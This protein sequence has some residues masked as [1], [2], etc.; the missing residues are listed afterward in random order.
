M[1]ETVARLLVQIE[2]LSPVHVGT[3]ESL[4]RKAFVSEGDQIHVVDER[5]LLA[6][7]SSSHRL[8]ESFVRFCENQGAWLREFL[9]QNRI[10]MR[11]VAAYTVGL[12]GERPREVLPFIKTAGSP[13]GAYLPGS[14]IKGA[15]R[16][17]LL[18][19]VLLDDERLR[20]AA[21]AQVE[22]AVRARRKPKFPGL[23]VEQ[24]FFG[25]DQHH[26]LMRVVQ[27]TDSRP[28]R[29]TRLRVAEV[30]T[31][32]STREGKLRELRFTLSPEVLPAGTRL[33]CEMAIKAYLISGEA[34]A[35]G[36]ELEGERTR[37]LLGFARECN[38]AAGDLIAQEIDFLSRHN[39]RDLV[40][41]YEELEGRLENLGDTACLLR[42]G[43]GTGFDDK[44]V[45][46]VFDEQLFDDVREAYRLP[47]G[48]PGRRGPGLPK[49]LSPKS[50]KIAFRRDGPPQPLGWLQ[51]RL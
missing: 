32:S 49:S 50:R 2:V 24:E 19:S 44:A 21:A 43:W 39:E 47:V 30:R 12:M 31:L 51:L 14:S 37:R 26:D 1:T 15:L 38:R 13:P 40:A 11:E 18:R 34:R 48:R 36:L 23:A 33:R 20:E 41:F 6:A 28:V 3:G 7:V 16:S 22:E 17:A 27:V 35:R 25:P 5:K 4:G 45:T 42:L 29:P 8:Q 10:P 46:D 9:I